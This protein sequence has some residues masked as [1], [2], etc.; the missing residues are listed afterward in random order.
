MGA[1][2]PFV[3]AVLGSRTPSEI[4]TEAVDGT[5]LADPAF[6]K[7][8]VEGGEAAVRASTN[9]MIVLARKVDP[10]DRQRIKSLEDNV[11]SMETPAGEKIGQARFAVYGKSLYPD[12]TFPPPGLATDRS[13]ATR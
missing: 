13:K 5:K 1:D 11:E 12:A 3:T 4:V 10:F 6:R 7:S 9:P 8:L 2:D